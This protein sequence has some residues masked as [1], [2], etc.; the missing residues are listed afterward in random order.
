M[1]FIYCN[2]LLDEEQPEIE[3]ELITDGRSEIHYQSNENLSK[4][5][6]ISDDV[7]S[8]THLLLS[9]SPL[10]STIDTAQEQKNG[11]MKP[12]IHQIHVDSGLV[13]TQ[14]VKHGSN[15]MLYVN[16]TR[17]SSTDG[18]LDDE[19]HG[20]YQFDEITTDN[21]R[22]DQAS[23]KQEKA[24]VEGE[25]VNS[26]TELEL[27]GFSL[28]IDT[29]IPSS[30]SLIPEDTST[31]KARSYSCIEEERRRSTIN[32]SP[33]IKRRSGSTSRLTVNGTHDQT[34]IV[35][36]NKSTSVMTSRASS[37]VMIDIN[38]TDNMEELLIE[39]TKSSED[40]LNDELNDTSSHASLLY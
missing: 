26:N 3:T 25:V 16:I 39:H 35:T 36:S 5:D 6:D 20:V 10:I 14:E 29:T 22:V 19:K 27:V 12:D 37:I 11:G 30:I 1:L 8:S 34:N 2:L 31:L 4:R 28:G 33:D 32:P 18:L 38:P 7:V 24:T 13:D 40:I 17:R 9:T 23:H 21:D 15:T